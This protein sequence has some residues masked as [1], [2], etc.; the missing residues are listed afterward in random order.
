METR[1]LHS[2]MLRIAP[3]EM[4]PGGGMAVDTAFLP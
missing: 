4:T 2:A 3:V 1:F